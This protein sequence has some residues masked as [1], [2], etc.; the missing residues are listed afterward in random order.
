MVARKEIAQSMAGLSLRI[1]LLLV[2]PPILAALQLQYPHM[3]IMTWQCFPPDLTIGLKMG[4]VSIVPVVHC[5]M[6]KKTQQKVKL[7]IFSKFC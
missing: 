4:Q 5:V 2:W 3:H 1:R 6:Q 7:N